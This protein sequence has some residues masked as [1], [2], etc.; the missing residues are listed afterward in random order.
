MISYL[1]DEH[2]GET[3]ALVLKVQ[4]ILA[5]E[6]KDDRR[7][8]G[9]VDFSRVEEMRA[10]R[11]RHASLTCNE[12][13]AIFEAIA[14]L[15]AEGA[16][17]AQKKH[18]VTLAIQA[19]RLPHGVRANTINALL[20]IAPQAAR[21]KLVLNLILSGETIPFNVVQAGI[22]EVFDDAK[23]QAW[24]LDDSWQLKTWLILLPFTDHSVQLAN[25]IAALPARHREPYILEEMLRACE[26]VHGPE[27]EEAL[28]L[29]AE[30]DATFYGNH[31]WR[32]AVRR[33]G[34]LASARRYLDLVME[35]KI[36]GR[37]GWHMSQEIA[38]LLK[39]HSELR[40]YAYGLLRDGSS[41]K[42]LMLADA[43]AE[44]G[45]SDGL[46]E[47]VELENRLRRSLIS[48]RIIQ[49]AIT[50]HVPSDHWHGAFE[51]LPIDATELRRKLLAIT[52]DGGPYDAAARVLRE[53]D[54]VRDENGAPEY[55]PRHPDLARGKPWPILVPDPDADTIASIGSG[56]S[57]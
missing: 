48:S 4:W 31:A 34:T 28:F 46:L 17:D 44:G 20:S 50:E 13:E 15:I 3:A 37:N 29:L 32:N 7:F 51:V 54:S 45:G 10:V 30:N 53:I 52:T 16:T 42:V 23:M 40:D 35:G 2:F 12:A 47:L 18:A 25:T 8:W 36:N 39:L 38:G 6:P 57:S 9:S 14:P 56:A 1:S 41:P 22:S 49:G 33:Q 11:A 19:L 26:A 43:V 21:A 24:I 55:E 5:N 27:I